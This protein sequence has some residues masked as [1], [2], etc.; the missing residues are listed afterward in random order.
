MAME[1]MEQ[2]Q[3]QCLIKRP[4]NVY[5][6]FKKPEA[7]TLMSELANQGRMPLGRLKEIANQTGIPY[8]TLE[9]W[10]AKLRVDPNYFSE[11][12]HKGIP[13]KISK[14]KEDQILTQLHEKFLQDGRYCPPRA[15][16]SI[17]KVNFPDQNFGNKWLRCYMTR[18]NLSSRVP[19]IKRRT[20]PNDEHVAAFLNNMELVKMQFPSDLILNVDEICWRII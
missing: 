13:R 3:Y 17:A 6:F 19:H 8:K 7:I 14:E 11:H 9:T 18:H 4:H 16:K 10:R 12:G 5:K 1:Q 2:V 20:A 15:I